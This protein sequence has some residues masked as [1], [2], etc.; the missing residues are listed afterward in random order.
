LVYSQDGK[1]IAHGENF[2]AA[3]EAIHKQVEAR[4]NT[5]LVA[6][7]VNC[8][9]PDFVSTLFQPL[10]SKYNL[11]VYP[12]SGELSEFPNDFP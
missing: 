10:N 11:I 1:S 7:G 8:I 12:N 5:N 6:I 2:A 9:N 3:V 4:G